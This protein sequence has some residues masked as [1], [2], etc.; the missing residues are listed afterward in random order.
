MDKDLMLLLMKTI[1][2]LLIVATAEIRFAS[3]PRNETSEE[4]L[5]GRLE[6]HLK[7]IDLIGR[8]LLG[9]DE[10][11]KAQARDLLVRELQRLESETPEFEA[12]AATSSLRVELAGIA[13]DVRRIIRNLETNEFHAQPNN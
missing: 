1:R 11:G 9:A 13:A 7:A 3:V 5:A 10:H 4:E 8:G 2:Q 12:L 6:A